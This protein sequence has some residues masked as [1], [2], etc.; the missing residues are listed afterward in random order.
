M[1]TTE[2]GNFKIKE[3]KNSELVLEITVWHTLFKGFG[4]W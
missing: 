1:V 2:S 3:F 4:I